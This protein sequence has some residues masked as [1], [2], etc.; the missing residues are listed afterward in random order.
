M[1]S[2]T[3]NLRED[4]SNIVLKTYIREPL[5]FCGPRPAIIVCPGGGYGFLSPNEGEPVALRFVS[6]GYNA[7]VLHYSVQDNTPLEKLSWPEPL[8][9]LASAILCIREHA[10]EW[11]VDPAQIAICGFSAGGHLVSM[12]ASLWNSSVIQE[13]FGRQADDF[14]INAAI[15]GYPVSDFTIGPC[16]VDWREMW[17]CD[18]PVA[19][20]NQFMFGKTD[21]TEE[22]LRAKSS[23]YLVNDATVPMFIAHAQDDMMVKVEGSLHLAEELRKHDIPFELHVFESGNHGFSLSDESSA[24]FDF[25]IN[26]V[27]AEWTRFVRRWLKKYL[28]VHVSDASKSPYPMLKR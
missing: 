12:Y 24:G 17:N 7:F 6:M 16:L 20:F 14:S 10:E 28:T 27:V 3:I 8:I 15:L 23:P 25:E 22:D 19:H 18:A 1:T 13:R 21:P 4:N 26:P 9:D 11:D 2:K 5:E